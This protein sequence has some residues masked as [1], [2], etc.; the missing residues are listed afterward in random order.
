M[1]IKYKKQKVKQEVGF[2]CDICEQIFPEMHMGTKIEH[3]FGDDSKYDCVVVNTIICE[4]CF[5]K[6]LKKNLN[7]QIFQTSKANNLWSQIATLR[8]QKE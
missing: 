1:P 8:L 5:Y 3:S 7:M 2:I 4:D 6:L